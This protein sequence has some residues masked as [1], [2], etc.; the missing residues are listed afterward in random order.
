ML[1]K[2]KIE[3]IR[4]DAEELYPLENPRKEMFHDNAGQYTRRDAHIYA[5][6]A[7]AQRAEV[8][9]KALEKIVNTWEDQE[10]SKYEA[11]SEMNA[12]ATQAIEQYNSKP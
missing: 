8:L 1:S 12:I 7:E 10:Y 9:V 6:T 2:E 4:K 5:A 11:G 3:Q